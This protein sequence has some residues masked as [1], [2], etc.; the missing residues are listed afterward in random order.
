MT[1]KV[2]LDRDTE[3]SET[4]TFQQVESGVSLV[5]SAVIGSAVVGS[6][7][8]VK[9]NHRTSRRSE[10]IQFRLSNG[11]V[12]ENF[13]VASTELTYEIGAEVA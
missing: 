9:K 2:Y 1:V 4:F 13:I 7:G 5:G 12:N 6:G 8:V 11:N 10:S 3:A